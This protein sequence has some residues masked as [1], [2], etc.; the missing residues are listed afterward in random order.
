MVVLTWPLA[1]ARTLP[2]P[3]LIVVVVIVVVV[4]WS[5]RLET[6]ELEYFLARV[7]CRLGCCCCSQTPLVEPY[8][9]A[10]DPVLVILVLPVVDVG[11]AIGVVAE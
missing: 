4:P 10:C 2:L 1:F 5:V 8:S 3:D 9:C 7:C 11:V 6:L